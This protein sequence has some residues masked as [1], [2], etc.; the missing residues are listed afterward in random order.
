[1][2]LSN[3]LISL[4]GVQHRALNNS[5]ALRAC[6][7]TNCKEKNMKLTQWKYPTMLKL[8]AAAITGLASATAIAGLASATAIAGAPNMAP[9]QSDKFLAQTDRLIVKYKDSVPAGKGAAKVAALSAER[10]A[11]LN[12]AGQQFGVTIKAL[13]TTATGANIFKL[14]RMVPLDDARALAAVLMA[15]DPM[16]EYAE[17]DRVMTRAMTPSPL[18]KN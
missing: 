12:R 18:R 11:L 6:G 2:N 8:C 4:Y 14:N 15:R 3:F 9:A 17:P 13:H 16:V 7:K 10:K 5:F 1:M